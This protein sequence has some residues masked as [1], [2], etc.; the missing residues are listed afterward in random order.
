MRGRICLVDGELLLRGVESIA[1]IIGSYII[2]TEI[3]WSKSVAVYSIFK[4]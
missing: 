3:E 2:Y 4:Q 1:V